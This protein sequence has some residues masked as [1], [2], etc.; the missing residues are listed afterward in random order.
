MKMKRIFLIGLTICLLLTSCHKKAESECFAL[1][2]EYSSWFVEKTSFADLTQDR[3]Y[4]AVMEYLD[5]GG[6]QE[7]QQGMDSW[8]EKFDS[9]AEKYPDN[10]LI[11]EAIASYKG[12]INDD[13]R[14]EINNLVP[15]LERYYEGVQELSP[16]ESFDFDLAISFIDISRDACKHTINKTGD[17]SIDTQAD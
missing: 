16:E 6:L 15:Y 10:Q 13:H 2:K 4:P 11:S 14:K 3:S 12:L 8:I 17:G 9:F 1:L 5:N 7:L